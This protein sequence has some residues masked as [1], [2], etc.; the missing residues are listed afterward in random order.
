MREFN[1][2]ELHPLPRPVGYFSPTQEL[3]AQVR[4]DSPAILVLTD[5]RQ[6]AAVTVAPSE[7]IDWALQRMKTVGV[8]LLFVVN[9]DEE[10]QGLITA[11]DIQGEKPVRLL[12]ELELRHEEILVRDVMTPCDQLEVMYMDD[13]MQAAVG[14]IV[15]TLQYS[16]RRHAL[17]LD[18]DPRSGRDAIR[19]LFSISQIGKQLGKLV[20]PVGV[21]RTFSELETALNG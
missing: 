20:E 19:G 14:D 3:P 7:S 5:L 11:N 13:V 15:V 12:R 8:R 9:A 16:G 17:V 6:Q 21:A 18:H 10:I 2:L 4:E 1:E